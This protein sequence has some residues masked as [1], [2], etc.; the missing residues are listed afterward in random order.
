MDMK[1]GTLTIRVRELLEEREWGPMD[2]VRRPEFAFAQ[3]TA[4]R[5]ARNEA[6]ALS[7][8]TIERLLDGFG[9]PIEELLVP[10][11]DENSG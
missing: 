4:Y 9:V 3:G 10:N 8:N 5:L 7:F 1:N 11:G 6:E 2:L